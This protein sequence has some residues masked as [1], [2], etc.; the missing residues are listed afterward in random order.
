MPSRK[1]KSSVSSR[2]P[3]TPP[4]QTAVANAAAH[5]QTLESRRQI[6]MGAQSSLEDGAM[7][8]DNDNSA[9]G[10]QAVMRAFGESSD[11]PE[12]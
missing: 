10:E 3:R 6:R 7:R 4:A 1:P 9:P 12:H 11:D 2:R 5:V 8:E